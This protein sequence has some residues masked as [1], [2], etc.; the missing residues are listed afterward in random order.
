MICRVDVPFFHAACLDAL[1]NFQGGERK[2]DDDNPSRQSCS[3]PSFHVM[4]RKPFRRG[5]AIIAWSR[6]INDGLRVSRN[7]SM[8]ITQSLRTARPANEVA[9]NI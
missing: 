1:L 7:A 8:S 9:V 4:H 2:N 6:R 3:T 5:R